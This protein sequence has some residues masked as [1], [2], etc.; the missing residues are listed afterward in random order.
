[1]T[2]VRRRL[3]FVVALLV[4]FACLTVYIGKT[5]TSP[6]WPTQK[7]SP[8]T[9]TRYQ[10]SL[11]GLNLTPDF[12]FRRQCLRPRQRR[13]LVRQ[14][15]SVFDV[16]GEFMTPPVQLKTSELLHPDVD[17]RLATPACPKPLTVDVPAPLRHV[18]KPDEVDTS[19][20]MLGMATSLKRL[21]ASLPEMAR[22]LADT[23]TPLLVILRDQ[24]TLIPRN[25]FDLRVLDKRQAPVADE[26]EKTDAAAGEAQSNFGL[27]RA[28]LHYKTPATKW[29][30]VIDD[31]TFFVSL[32]ATVRA[33]AP[34]ATDQPYYVGA[35]SE[36]HLGMNTEGFKAWGGAGI[37]M[38][39]PLIT[40]LAANFDTCIRLAGT[41]GDALWRDCIALSTA[42]TVQLTQLPGL[43]QLD[44]F[45]G[46][47]GWFESGP[48][49][50]LT[51]HHWKS[52]YSFPIPEA[53]LVTALAGPH[54][55]FARFAFRQGEQNITL[56]NGYSLV[57]YPNG[58]PDLS[59]TE[60]TF[61]AYPDAGPDDAVREYRFS[62]GRLRPK[63]VEGT[64]KRSWT[65][66]H[67]V[68]DAGVAR[69]FYVRRGGGAGGMDS[70]IEVD[71]VR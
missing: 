45:P 63:L 34:F 12:E 19:M 65:L 30:G 59:L 68:L 24:L 35:L 22:W 52:W 21:T 69:Q 10:S 41:W 14:H 70:V 64:E 1:M 8:D 20:L 55:L 38:T 7:H 66:E 4:S 40:T 39:L 48:W 3:Y 2:L 43:H 13:G 44:M 28:F 36:R 11:S 5:S 62:L 49:P 18:H 61:T 37:F 26:K 46:V 51:L 6:T 25:Q 50:I 15:G 31:D 16:Q 23:S 29:F 42:P 56:T 60:N 32:P 71:W 33:L 9:P 67:A 27:A 54:S 57:E 53:H 17:A 58:M 47:A